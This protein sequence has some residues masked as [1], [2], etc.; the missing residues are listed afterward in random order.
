MSLYDSIQTDI[1]VAMKEKNAIKVST[2]RMLKSALQYALIEKNSESPDDDLVMSII[3][4]QVKQRKDSIE[5]FE[6]GGRADLKEKEEIELNIL[7]EYLP[8]Q[9]SDDD[10]SAIIKDAI[11]ETG[12][13]SKKEMGLV[14]KAVMKKAQGRADGKRVNQLASQLL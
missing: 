4:K 3:Q 1:K 5:N 11:A 9:L 13:S 12:A 8:A 2:L 6:K 7:T 10:L 14:M